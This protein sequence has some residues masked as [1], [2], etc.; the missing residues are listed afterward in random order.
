MYLLAPFILQ[1][2]KK[3]LRANLVM[4]MCHFRAKNDLFVLNKTCGASH[5]YYFHLTI[6]PFLGE[7]FLAITVD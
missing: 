6:G 4:M 1:I 3:I 2:L 7:P 5:Y